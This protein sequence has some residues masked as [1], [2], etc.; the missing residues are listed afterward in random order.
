MELTIQ[1]RPF[2]IKDVLIIVA[3]VFTFAAMPMLWNELPREMSFYIT[4][5]AAALMLA[6]VLVLNAY[7]LL[8]RRAFVL[9]ATFLVLFAL[10]ASLSYL[11]NERISTAQSEQLRYY[12]TLLVF[13][14]IYFAFGGVVSARKSTFGIA[15]AAIVL[16]V[17]VVLR[18]DS[19]SVEA[20]D[21]RLQQAQNVDYQQLGDSIAI[22]V[23]ILI[24]MVKQRW[25]ALA[26]CVPAIGILFLIPSRSAAL[27]GS[28]SLLLTTI[29]RFPFR[30]RMALLTIVAVGSLLLMDSLF[31]EFGVLVQGSRHESIL[32]PGEDQSN[33]E[34][35][36]IFN[37]GMK[38]IKQR[39]LIGQ[40][41]FEYAVF[42][43]G[44]RYMHNALDIW[45][46]AGALPFI[47]FLVLW[48]FF[49]RQAWFLYQRDTAAA[50]PA[51][52]LLL[53][54]ALSWIFARQAA[55]TIQYFCLGYV[56]G[57]L[58][59]AFLPPSEPPEHSGM[60]AGFTAAPA[61]SNAEPK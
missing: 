8:E 5:S 58:R 6:A 32:T 16:L 7:D 31:A 2:G 15:L 22:C 43:E 34:R 28:I 42:G 20:I 61:A 10:A 30:I 57:A 35:T 53:F 47:A 12:W 41:G 55:S 25:L 59:T 60:A 39:P 50:M 36:Q 17:Y 46:Q 18:R 37:E 52:G 49:C 29:L 24:P 23:L 44:G 54:A 48:A 26:L 38:V 14:F 4:A 1:Q 21:E 56:A 45:A 51:I 33:R 19:F 11:I 3:A 40:F 9:T 13:C 27:F